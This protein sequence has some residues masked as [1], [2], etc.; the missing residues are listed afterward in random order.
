MNPKI[1]VVSD[2]LKYSIE[3]TIHTQDKELRQSPQA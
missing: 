2:W 3:E 1:H